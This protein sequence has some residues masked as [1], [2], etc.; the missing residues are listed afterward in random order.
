[1]LIR[2]D[3][4]SGPQYLHFLGKELEFLVGELVRPGQGVS[5]SEPV[6]V[7]KHI[8]GFFIQTMAKDAE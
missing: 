5:P 8:L 1:M 7:H 3:S 4:E 6:A 2:G